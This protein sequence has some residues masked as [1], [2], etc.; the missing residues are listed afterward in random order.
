MNSVLLKRLSQNFGF[1]ES[2]SGFMGKSGPDFG[3]IGPPV[4]ERFT[5]L[6]GFGEMPGRYGIPVPEHSANVGNYRL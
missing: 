6:T 1:R 2:S 3:P 5:K 4:Q